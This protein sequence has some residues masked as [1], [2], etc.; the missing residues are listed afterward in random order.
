M[1]HNDWMKTAIIPQVRVEPALRTELESV[2]REGETLSEFVE[3]TVRD[4]VA[5]R[6]DEALFQARGEAAWR[7]YQETGVSVP[8]GQVLQE[9]HDM[10]DAKRRVL[11]QKHDGA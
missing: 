4:A 9:L 1:Q 6:R 7:A 10:L 5:F 8:A 3:S 11:L 2:L